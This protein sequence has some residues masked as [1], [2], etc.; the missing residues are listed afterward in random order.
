[1]KIDSTL[2]SRFI[3]LLLFSLVFSGT[4]GQVKFSAVAS[5]K[6]IG[7]SDYVQIEFVV[8]NA[9]QIED[10]T[11]PSF[12]DFQ[13]VKGPIQ[14]SGMSIINGAMSQYKALSFVLQPT[15]MGKFTLPGAT[16]VI[17]G[18]H[19]TSNP[20][21]I[22]VVAG[23]R[24]AP[25]QPMPHP[26]WPGDDLDF[27]RE[28]ILRPGENVNEKIRKNMFVKVQVSKTSCFVGESIVATYKLYSRLQS[29]S[30][31]TRHP[32]LNGFSVHDMIDPTSD[33]SFIE[34]VN[35]KPFTVHIIRK[36]QL[37]P[38]QAGTVDLDPV[39]VENTV[40]FVKGNGPVKR[41]NS[42]PLQELFD[43]FSGDEEAG[44]RVDQHVVLDSKP[45]AIDVKGLPLENRP[46]SFNGAVGQ[47]T[48]TAAMDTKNIVAEDAAVLKLTVKGSGNLPVVN[49]P[50]VSWPKG[51]E[52]YSASAREQVDKTVAPMNGFKTF[53]YKFIPSVA[54]TYTIPP[55]AFS[56]FDPVKAVYKT[57]ETQAFDVG[58][59]KSR[60][61]VGRPAILSVAAKEADNG[62]ANFFQKH[63]EWFFAILILS[64]L[65]VYLLIQNRQLRRS[66]EQI[67]AGE[68]TTPPSA[69][70]EVVALP[71]P[72]DPLMVSKQLL[73]AGEY[74]AFY[75]EL[76]RAIWNAIADKLQLRASELNKYNIVTQLAA[77]GWDR[78]Q[79]ALLEDTLNECEMK[80]YTPDHSETDLQRSLQHAEQILQGLN[81]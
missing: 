33:V 17:D 22:D 68:K 15:K 80:L 46:E 71:P 5:S 77:R 62:I 64:G 70:E 11:P 55:V 16:A 45:V 25:A 18:K 63:L 75:K 4:M 43:R 79:T 51:I 78:P 65:A 32:S 31:V 57:L 14:S 23:S 10:I 44:E 35:G 21:T 12:H 41:R 30:R 61:K 40:H 2:H 28:Y 3:M 72:P 73:A 27:D 74:N 36:A 13:V 53:E 39:E 26:I 1:M 37:I 49:A 8:E 47:F 76:N 66:G 19:M 69:A 38:L 24:A 81:G 20:V 9:Q 6:E 59:S 50:T 48:M 56:Y 60:A 42:N 58:V 67:K 54:G 52:D 34:S 29:E 7:K